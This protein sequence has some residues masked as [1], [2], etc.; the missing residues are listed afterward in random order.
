M[1]NLRRYN[2]E[3]AVIGRMDGHGGD[4]E[5][6][7]ARVYFGQCSTREL[8]EYGFG[9]YE[10]AVA[11]VTIGTRQ[12]GE[13]S[14]SIHTSHSRVDVWRV[15]IQ[16]TRS[17][18]T[19]NR[20]RIVQHLPRYRNLMGELFFSTSGCLCTLG[21][22]PKPMALRMAFA[23]LRW[24][25]GRSPVSLECFIRPVSVMYSDI[26]VKFCYRQSPLITCN[27]HHPPCTRPR[28]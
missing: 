6:D 2:V 3:I 26:M 19:H 15:L 22:R 1:C 21:I 28:G 9:E 27:P 24:F 23:I 8:S 7:K 12:H 5:V 20:A 16:C 10:V 13:C 11:T 4:G 18:C 17:Y 14:Y 25:F